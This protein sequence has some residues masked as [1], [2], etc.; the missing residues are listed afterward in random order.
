MHD[1]LPKSSPRSRFGWA[2]FGRV[3]ACFVLLAVLGPGFVKTIQ[4]VLTPPR[5]FFQDWAAAR[6]WTEG[7]PIYG[8]LREAARDYLHLDL[9]GAELDGFVEV[10]GHP[11]TALWPAL[12][13]ARIEF[14]TAFLIWDLA[15]LGLVVVSLV[16]IGREFGIAA[17]FKT[18]SIVV[19]LALWCNPLW[20][21]LSQGQFGGLL[22]FLLTAGWLA[23]RR[24]RSDWAGVCVGLAA[25]VKLYPG[26]IIGYWLLSG[27]RS[28]VK[29]ALATLVVVA[30]ATAV[31]F[32]ADT[33]AIYVREVL[34]GMQFWYGSG[35]NLSLTGFWHRLF[36]EPGSAFTP[37]IADGAIA[38][39]G[40][41]LSN[42]AVLGAWGFTVYRQRKSPTLDGA[43]A[44][45]LAA[46]TLIS[47]LAWDHHLVVL[48]L[49]LVWAWR[50]TATRPMARAI[51]AVAAVCL[52]I[53]PVMIWRMYLGEQFGR[54]VLSPGESMTLF[55]FQCY[56]MIC[57][58]AVTTRLAWKSCVVTKVNSL[59]R[60]IND[61]FCGA[62]TAS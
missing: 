7:R 17:N 53:S 15:S 50:E 13:F 11:P 56:A 9:K 59:R 32:G 26:L 16:M 55:S 61:S 40:T 27:R 45:T 38:R 4:P 6:N 58:F 44:V 46:M 2:S 20:Q 41:A 30:V 19:I 31:V 51:L 48:L 52:W 28:Q 37:I 33:F 25:A 23:D 49:P 34:P 29:S 35:L 8:N 24:G 18:L 3:I 22:L 39:L 57:L 54:T 14:N 21:L 10:N 47:P 62:P 12:P 42:L 60:P 43:W 36:H 5:D 1:A